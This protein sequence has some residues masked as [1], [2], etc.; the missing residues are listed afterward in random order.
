MFHIHVNGETKGPYAL[1]QIQTMWG[2]GAITADTQ[3]WHEGSEKWLPV[4]ELIRPR[5][6][7]ANPSQ[8]AIPR[9]ARNTAQPPVCPRCGQSDMIAKVSGLYAAG[10]S[11]VPVQ[12]P[13]TGAQPRVGMIMTP[14]G[15]PHMV[16]MGGGYGVVGSR[17]EHHISESELAARLVPQEE[18]DPTLVKPWKDTFIGALGITFCGFGCVLFMMAGMC[19]LLVKTSEIEMGLVARFAAM[20]VGACGIGA[21]LIYVGRKRWNQS[22]APIALFDDQRRARWQA[23]MDLWNRCYYCSRDDIVFDPTTGKSGQPGCWENLL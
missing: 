6:T 19:M 16:A 20:G 7:S 22:R 1:D 3:Y 23:F 9:L 5:R 17:T 11:S 10:R 4:S 8:S 13:V 2:A 12:V 21:P 15:N 18:P 14:G